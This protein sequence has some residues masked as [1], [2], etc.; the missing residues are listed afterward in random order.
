VDH[1]DNNGPDSQYGRQRKRRLL[2]L[3]VFGLA[4]VI[5]FFHMEHFQVFIDDA[6]ISLRYARNL[7]DGRG[8]VYNPGERVEGYTN[9]LWTMM[10]AASLKLGLNGVM[11]ARY[12]GVSFSIAVLLLTSLFSAVAFGRSRPGDWAASLL[13]S[14]SGC[15]AFWSGAGLEN[16]LFVFTALA[17]QALFLR[18]VERPA[19]KR[20]FSW[21]GMF[22]LTYFARPDG[23]LFFAVAFFLRLFFFREGGLRAGLRELAGAC[24]VFWVPVLIHLAWRYGY[25]GDLLP[26]TFYVKGKTDYKRIY[27]GLD[28]LWSFLKVYSLLLP[29]P[30]F[31]VFAFKRRLKREVSVLLF[32]AVYLVYVISVGGDKVFPYFRLFMVLL[33]NL[34][35]LI[36]WGLETLWKEVSERTSVFKAA[37]ISAAYLLLVSGFALS[38]SVKGHDWDRTVVIRGTH[39]DGIKIGAWLSVS[40]PPETWIALNMAGTVPY[41]SGMPTIDMLGLTDRHI[42][43][44]A[45]KKQVN[46]PMH[47][48]QDFEYVLDRE[49]TIIFYWLRLFEKPPVHL[50]LDQV[51]WRQ[52]GFTEIKDPEIEKRFRKEYTFRIF[53]VG[54][55]YIGLFV[56]RGALDGPFPDPAP[57]PDTGDEE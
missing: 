25:Y 13:L 53:R 9:F 56:R 3:A 1:E 14:L 28:Y 23:G 38:A 27:W 5:F 16:G 43:Y 6:Y 12:L 11:T 46:L 32:A 54:E 44:R 48:K 49:P 21:G 8:L 17:G 50:G 39:Q 19:L 33:P 36:G 55:K 47:E 15:F 29:A 45:H 42:A 4:A 20:G 10:L 40:F 52:V 34:Y 51:S 2:A 7:A 37:A 18:K 24:A 30:L 22:A 31:L 57:G 26:N 41:F 35:L